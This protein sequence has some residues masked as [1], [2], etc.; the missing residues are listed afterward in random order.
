[1]ADVP[2]RNPLPA[3]VCLLALTL[4][5]ALVW[6]RVLNRGDEHVGANSPCT[7]Q[8]TQTVLPRPATVVVSVLNSTQ[9]ARIAKS[10]A[11][12]LT[13]YG[14]KVSGYANDTGHAVIPGVA[15][16]RFGPDQH[17]AA[18][19]LNYY[20][21]G[22]KLL[23]VESRADGTVVVSLGMKYKAVATTAVANAAMAGDK[24]TLAPTDSP[25]SGSTASTSC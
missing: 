8:N 6:W 11:A 14:F 3:L 21:P 1:M 24:V 16:I 7:P 19:L 5:T 13:K 25:S 10:A 18:T 2:K 22:A 15:E 12:S 9:R 4:L 17:N 20:F 23:P